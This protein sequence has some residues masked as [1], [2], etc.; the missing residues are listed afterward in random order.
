[1]LKK[2]DDSFFSGMRHTAV[3]RKLRSV[4]NRC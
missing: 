2:Q 1:M 4:R 3:V